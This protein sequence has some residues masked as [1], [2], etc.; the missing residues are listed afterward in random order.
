MACAYPRF[1]NVALALG[2]SNVSQKQP[3]WTEGYRVWRPVY[4]L[5]LISP[6][7]LQTKGFRDNFK[8]NK[9][10]STTISD[11]LEMLRNL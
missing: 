6:E 2:E 4:V 3:L 9:R 5:R 7:T 8:L 11:V 1:E 10:L